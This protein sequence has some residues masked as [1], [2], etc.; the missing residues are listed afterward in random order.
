M[1]TSLFLLQLIGFQLWHATSKQ[2]AH[3]HA[4]AYLLHV[5]D[6]TS[7]FRIIGGIL[8]LM[9]TALFIWKWGWMTGI[10][11]S[12]VGLMGLGSLVVSLHPFR[13]IS[14]KVV[15]LG[16]AFFLILEQFI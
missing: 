2:V 1:I 4:P 16:Y 3:N 6:N 5:L 9:S 10:C 14:Q 8:F 11:A 7:R 15:F 13:Y 12:I